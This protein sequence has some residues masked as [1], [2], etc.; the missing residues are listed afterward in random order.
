MGRPRL[1]SIVL[2]AAV[3]YTVAVLLLG[4]QQVL[5][6][7]RNGTLALGQIL[8]PH[9][10][11]LAALLVPLALLR[12]D[13]TT[14][15]ARRVLRT[16]LVG[17]L[18]VGALRFGPGLV[19]LPASSPPDAVGLTVLSWN[20]E[21]TG[22][23]ARDMHETLLASSAEVVGLQELTRSAAAALEDDPAIVARFPSM[24]LNPDDDSTGIG[25]LARHP[26]LRSGWLEDPSAAWA[27]LDLG[28][29]RDVLAVTAHPL[30][31]RLE[32]VSSLRVPVW[33]DA[34]ERDEALIRLRREL[35][36][37]AVL[38]RDPVVLFG[39]FNVTDREPAYRDLTR[40]MSDAHAQVGLGPGSTWRPSRLEWLPFGLLRID[41]VFTAGA[42]SPIWIESDCT[43]RQSDHCILTAG[44]AVE[45]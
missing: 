16:G 15:R 42:A 12:P 40:D 43:P 6:P 25:L 38:A 18:I 26:F 20:L 22:S 24:V 4:A 13:A 9:M 2:W 29:G 3:A 1:L 21:A 23:G 45:P 17:V 35:V 5:A 19:S 30:A 33:L 31:A 34:T 27:L 7:Q 32:V 41:Y 11:L 28:A 37:G 39:D 8:A 36:D 44:I 10:T 14:D